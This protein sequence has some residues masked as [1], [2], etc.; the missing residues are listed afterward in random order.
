[1]GGSGASGLWKALCSRLRRFA[2]ISSWAD[3]IRQKFTRLIPASSTAITVPKAA[4][5]A[6]MKRLCIFFSI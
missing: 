6:R 2:A 5:A 4:M 3:V 1:M